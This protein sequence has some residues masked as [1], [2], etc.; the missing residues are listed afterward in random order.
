MQ[1]EKKKLRNGITLLVEHRDVPVVSCSI[2]M[3]FG[4]AFE[5]A[6]EK[7]AAHF[8]EHLLF[9][10][11]KTRTHEDISKEIEK[12]G[13]ILNAFTAHE[14][15]SYWF[16]LPSV[17]LF[18]GLDIITDMLRNP[19]FKEEK[20]EKEK[21]VILEEIKMYHDSPTR[22]VYDLLERNLYGDPFGMNIIGTPETVSSLSRDFVVA[23]FKKQ[24]D[25]GQFVVTAVGNVDVKQLV[26]YLERTFAP[27]PVENKVQPLILT[28]GRTVEA[29]PGL[30]QAHFILGMHAPS[31]GS[32]DYY[33]LEVLDAYLAHGMSSRLFLTIR[34]EKGLAYSV[35]SS[36]QA[37]QS[38]SYYCI[39]VGTRKDAVKQVEELIVQGF[40]DVAQMTAHDLVLAKQQLIGLRQVASEESST[41][42][43][44][45]LFAELGG[46][47]EDYYTREQQIQAVTLEE[48]QAL[49]QNLIS[50]KY[51]T[52][53][54][55]PQ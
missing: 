32:K 44:E 11:T 20:F 16:K 26:A 46:K 43:N 33:V 42:M 4:G 23:Y 9:T 49:A 38:Y 25:P 55:V 39:Y 36:L 50:K 27:S 28:E 29:R 35:K 52:A 30:D 1:F 8:I 51:S 2:S 12:K 37:E 47:A 40:K 18:A 21:K 7:G 24:Y 41:V 53:A 3:P 48:V 45:L 54:I 22:H 31:L 6:K 14:V 10:G 5:L 34:E 15:T 13:G 17:H 19:A